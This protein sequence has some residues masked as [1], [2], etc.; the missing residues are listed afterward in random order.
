MA[1]SLAYKNVRVQRHKFMTVDDLGLALL[2]IPDVLQG[3]RTCGVDM[4]QFRHALTQSIEASAEQLEAGSPHDTQP[5]LEFQRVLQR[6]VYH[7]QSRGAR[8]VTG[9]G[10]MTAIFGEE[11]CHTVY[12][13]KQQGVDRLTWINNVDL[14]GADPDVEPD[15]EYNTVNKKTES[16]SIE[17]NVSSGYIANEISGGSN[18]IAELEARVAMLEHRLAELEK[19]LP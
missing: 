16:A 17:S 7:A 13:L 15:P 18:R 2:N 8:Q 5:T 14:G 10:V 11:T 9:V 1:I 3:L 12:H 4:E 19:K 6:A